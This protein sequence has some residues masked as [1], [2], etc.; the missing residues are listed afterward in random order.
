MPPM[1]TVVPGTKLLPAIVIT[2]PPVAGPVLGLTLLMLGA[3][4]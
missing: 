2:V 4:G 1:V 3:S